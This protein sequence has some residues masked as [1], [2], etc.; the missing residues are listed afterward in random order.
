MVT[1][2]FPLSG[3]PYGGRSTYQLL[4]ALTERVSVEVV[5][6][7]PRYPKGFRSR[8][9][10]EADVNFRVPPLSTTYIRYPSVPL[11]T[12]PINGMICARYIE[13]CLRGIAPDVVLNFWIY[14]QGRG[15]LLAG[16]RVGAKVIVGAIGTDLNVLPGRV[17]AHLTL[18]TMLEADH[19]ITKSN[20][21]RCRAV[22]MGVPA[23][24]VTAVLNGCDRNLFSPGDR[25]GARKNLNVSLDKSLIVFVGRLELAKGIRE[26]F[27]ACREL[28]KKYANLQLAYV[29]DGP[30]GSVLSSLKAQVSADWLLLPGST[31]AAGVAQWLRACN[32][33]ALPSYA[34]GCPNVVLEAL[35]CGRPVVATNVGGVPE[36][37]SGE[38]GE[39]VS[40]RDSVAL[41]EAIDRV[42]QQKWDERK[43]ASQF[44]RGWDDMADEVCRILLK[45]LGSTD[46]DAADKHAI[47]RSILL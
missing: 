3:H 24:K 32:L 34:E 21:L 44:G 36:V 15:A 5:C 13:D 14:P 17:T 1:P 10:R 8:N 23:D 25:V 30:A 38:G 37:L 27:D 4:C 45:V 19:V 43:L 33:L 42:L 20:K 11:V 31:D 7:I 18:R 28:R 16:R 26:L 41:A 35:C 12:R 9:Y 39:L 2:F 46:R 22:E 40:P 47:A 29:G 6:P